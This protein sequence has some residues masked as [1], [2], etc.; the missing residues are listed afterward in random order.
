MTKSFQFAVLGAVSAAAL[1]AISA[2]PASA[3]TL[4]PA[5]P[6]LTCKVKTPEGLSYTVITA[7]KGEKPGPDSKVEV[8]YSGRLASDGSEFDSGEGAKFKV[9]GV[10]A[11]FAQGLKLMQPGGKYRLCIPSALG[12]GPEGGDPIPPN[13][14]L[15]FEVELLSFTTPPPKPVIAS[16]DRVCAQ[17]TTSGLG[18]SIVTA[19]SGRTPTDADMALVDFTL[20]D[21]ESGVVQEKR[22][23]EKIPLAMA[24]PLFAEALK[25]MPSGS[26]YRFCM[27][28]PDGTMGAPQS[29]TNIIV[30]LIDV[31]PA[32]PAED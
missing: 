21:A 16:A 30:T 24:T 3:A 11:G 31:R 2:L 27:P 23:W 32:P 5:K 6:E 12:Y 19:G 18:Y 10:I 15:V 22:E 29:G 4:A 7:G 20:F 1:L 8:N 14:D 26:T 25:M 28:K 13:A 9:S 17:S